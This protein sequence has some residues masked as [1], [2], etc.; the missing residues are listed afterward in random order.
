MWMKRVAICVFSLLVCVF[1]VDAAAQIRLNEILADPARDWDGDATLNSRSDEWVEIVNVGV[2]TVDLAS[3]RIGDASGETEF[4][5]GFTG[6][7]AP[8]ATLV[9]FGSQSVAWEQANGFTAVGLSL[10]NAG[11][12]VY[13]F[14]LSGGDTIV[15]DEYTYTDFEVLD[16]RATG[17]NPDG[18]GP[19]EIF[20]AL[21]P[22][23]G[24]T[25]P[26]GNGCAPTP[27]E[28]NQCSG[29]VPVKESTWGR[30]KDMYAK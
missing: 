15:V 17:R 1:A 16:D 3:Y 4:R 27:G 11:D 2:S 6:T 28:T 7:L 26:L 21:N 25:L 29:T 22:Y 23:S 18:T 14:E 9:V 8:G 20:D 10:N 30:I 13:L 12:T 5:Y 19:W 24:P